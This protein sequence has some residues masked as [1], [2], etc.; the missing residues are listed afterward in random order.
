V[1]YRDAVWGLFVLL[2]CL[3]SFVLL[4]ALVKTFLIFFSATD[5]LTTINFVFTKNILNPIKPNPKSF[6]RTLNRNWQPDQNRVID[7]LTVRIPVTC[8]QTF[9][10]LRARHKKEK[11]VK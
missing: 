2:D 5:T 6:P 4:K 8:P 10:A 11:T 9:C 7:A 1:N 3:Y